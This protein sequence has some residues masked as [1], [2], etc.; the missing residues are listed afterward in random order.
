[1]EMNSADKTICIIAVS[2]LSALTII[3]CTS[4]SR[5]ALV[6]TEKERT[7]QLR[8]VYKLDSLRAANGFYEEDTTSTNENE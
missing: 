4:K 8:L 7:E 1:M 2:I 5:E 6:K 3:V